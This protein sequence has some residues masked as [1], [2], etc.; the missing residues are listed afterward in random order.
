[1]GSWEV[2][3]RSESDN[4][5]EQNTWREKIINEIKCGGGGCNKRGGSGS[6]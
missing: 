6:R 2:I 1:M 3:K 4:C 5:E